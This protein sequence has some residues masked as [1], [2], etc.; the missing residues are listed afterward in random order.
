MK[1]TGER[2]GGRG[3]RLKGPQVP[4]LAARILFDI[5][6]EGGGVILDNCAPLI[7]IVLTI[8]SIFL[9]TGKPG[10]VR[11][12]LAQP[13]DSLIGEKINYVN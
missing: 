10:E 6:N 5:A 8:T 13:S 12:D 4:I 9:G 2:T 11:K 3:F 1:R 7:E